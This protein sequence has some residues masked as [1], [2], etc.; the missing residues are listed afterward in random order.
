MGR[1]VPSQARNEASDC[2]ETHMYRRA[3]AATYTWPKVVEQLHVC[4]TDTL[5]PVALYAVGLQY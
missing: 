4:S 1:Q 5:K 3:A 2:F